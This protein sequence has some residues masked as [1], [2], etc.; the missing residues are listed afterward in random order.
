MSDV[1]NDPRFNPEVDEEVDMLFNCSIMLGSNL[2]FLDWLHH[3]LHLLSS[4]HYPGNYDRGVAAHQQEQ[5]HEDL[6]QGEL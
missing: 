2:L 1:Y 3:S 4:T 5:R 6:H